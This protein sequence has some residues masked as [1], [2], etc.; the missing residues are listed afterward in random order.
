MRDQERYEESIDRLKAAYG[1][2]ATLRAMVSGLLYRDTMAPEAI[3]QYKKK[4]DAVEAELL[5][6]A[7]NLGLITIQ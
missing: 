6:E 2:L 5:Q 4:L 1:Q 7:K 3:E